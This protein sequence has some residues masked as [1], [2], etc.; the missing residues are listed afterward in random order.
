MEHTINSACWYW[1]KGSKWG[2]INPKADRNDFLAITI[3]VNGGF[4]HI[5]ERFVALNKLAK[6]IGAQHCE[7]NSGMIFSNYEINKSA[8]FETNYYRANPSRVQAAI[9]AVNAKKSQI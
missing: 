2:D 8:I 6:L 7:T 4:N 3:A 9:E 5:G 1:R